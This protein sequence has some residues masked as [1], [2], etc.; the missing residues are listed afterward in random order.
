MR[1]GDTAFRTIRPAPY[2]SRGG[3]AHVHLT[4]TPP[5]GVEFRVDAIEF[6]DDPLLTPAAHAPPEHRRTGHRPAGQRPARRAARRAR[7]HP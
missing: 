6:D 4:L 7:H 1:R 3:P 5:G 2:P